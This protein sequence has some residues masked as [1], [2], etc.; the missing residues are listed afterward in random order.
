MKCFDYIQI[1]LI[2]VLTLFASLD[3]IAQL[4]INFDNGDLSGWQG[5]IS[6]FQV[7]D[8]GQLQ[9]MAPEEG[10]SLIYTNYELSSDT[11]D[12]ELD[13]V[14]DMAPSSSNFAK[15]YF[16]LDNNDIN[17][18]NGY[19]LRLGQSGTDDNISMYRLVAGEEELLANGTSGAIA[20][21]PA[22]AKVCLTWYP[23]GLFSLSADY[24]FEGFCE[25]EYELIDNTLDI[26]DASIF[27]IYCQYTNS[28][29]ENFY[30]DNISI[31]PFVRDTEPP[32]VTNLNVLSDTGLQLTFNE[33]VDA[34]TAQI[35]S[36]YVVN[37]GIG[38]P[39]SVSVDENVV[40]LVFD[41]A[42][43]SGVDYQLAVMNIADEE[44]NI[45]VPVALPFVVAVSP[46]NGDLALSEILFNPYSGGSD[47]VEI[48]NTSDK[49]LKVDGLVISN[50]DKEESKTVA[51]DFILLPG[52]Y[53]CITED[54]DFLLENYINAVSEF[55]IETD[56]PSFN[57]DMGNVSIS[58]QSDPSAYF[59]SYNYNEDDHFELIDEKDG[60][61]LER[62][63]FQSSVMDMNNWHSAAAAVGFAT[64]G[65]KNSNALE[66]ESG[67]EEFQ[68]DSKVFSPNQDGNEDLLVMQY[69]LDKPGY[70]ANIFIYDDE[71]F[72]I[73]QL[74]NNQLLGANGLI[75]WDGSNE[76]GNISELG[77]YIVVVDL[78]HTDGETKNFKKVCVLADFI[79]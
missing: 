47:F 16:A 78:F 35:A 33:R 37:E 54:K 25:L 45:I 48:F 60:V 12:I 56:L 53:L 71:G 31:K 22:Q 50:T 52:Q 17:T 15:I 43:T 30:Y 42:F 49:Y 11:F 24:T 4:E 66:I 40:Y 55:I 77:M 29:K 9:L 79:K 20:N 46:S 51:S 58:H 6:D 74:T 76:E 32:V 41:Q 65:A 10:A 59:E 68:F 21:D 61:S 26:S 5:D 38:S 13:F 63:S 18:A 36:N 2:S 3:S 67:N 27:A 19:M 39:S 28:R 34:S 8:E 57:N 14:L 23:Y 44:N 75:T 1:C 72:E 70:V 62:L 73:K 69:N 64:P 7:N